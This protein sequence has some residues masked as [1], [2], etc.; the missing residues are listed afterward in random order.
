MI[1]WSIKTAQDAACFDSIIV[2]TDDPEIASIARY[3]QAEVPFIR[4][5]S[6]SDDHSG[7]Q[8]VVTHAIKQMA[9]LGH[10]FESVCCLF[11][12]APFAYSTDIQ[13]ALAML[14]TASSMTSVFPVTSYPFPVQRSLRINASGLCTP[15]D[16]QGIL[17]RSQDLEELFHDAGQFYWATPE[18]WFSNSHLFDHGLPLPLP[19]WRVQDIDT[20]EDWY[21]A[22]LL[23]SLL[24]ESPL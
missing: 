21:R 6:L 11:A 17:K 19:C 5:Q 18:R 20:E 1:S 13:Q 8:S 7:I 22:E 10:E 2:S 3:Y 23:H 15:F 9:F 16:K 14:Q 24:A 12:T 4:P